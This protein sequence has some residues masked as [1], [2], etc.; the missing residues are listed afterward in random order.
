MFE[1]L[2]LITLSMGLGYVLAYFKYC[3]DAEALK[4]PFIISYQLKGNH[5]IEEVTVN[6]N[7]KAVLLNDAKVM[8][9]AVSEITGED[10]SNIRI[11]SIKTEEFKWAN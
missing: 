3:N 1:N 10:L 11:V 5:V 7:T 8:A 9:N 6:I 4:I 2:V